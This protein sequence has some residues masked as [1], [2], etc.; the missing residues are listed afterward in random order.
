VLEQRL[1]EGQVLLLLDGLDEVA[2]AGDRRERLIQCIQAFAKSHD[3]NRLLVT[4]RPYAY[5]QQHWKIQGFQDTTLADFGPR[6]IRLFVDQWYTNRPEFDENSALN[7]AEE[8]KKTIFAY[9]A[10]YE[11]A[12]RPLLLTLMAFLHSNRH[13]LPERRADLYERLLELLI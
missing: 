4:A 10:L 9:P 2:E 12:Q 8:L 6:Q 13:E 11:L 7:R 3:N 5:Q 1:R